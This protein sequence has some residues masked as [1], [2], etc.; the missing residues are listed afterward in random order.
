MADNP[1]NMNDDPKQSDAPKVS[2]FVRFINNKNNLYWIIIL[3]V[4]LCVVIWRGEPGIVLGYLGIISTILSIVLACFSIAFTFDSTR[5][6]RDHKRKIQEEIN[7][8]EAENN[9]FHEVLKKGNTQFQDELMNRIREMGT[10]ISH[11]KGRFDSIPLGAGAQLV[12][13]PNARGE[14]PQPQTQEAPNDIPESD[15]NES[16]D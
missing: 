14:D 15:Q 6:L 11:L 5:E 1:T 12:N 16:G 13:N 2:G 8:L 4:I 3:L 9:S 7:K 10:E